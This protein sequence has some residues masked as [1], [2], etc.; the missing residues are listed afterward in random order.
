MREK[1]RKLSPLALCV[2]VTLGCNL[3]NSGGGSRSSGGSGPSSRS[4]DVGALAGTTWKGKLKCD[5]G[6]ELDANYRFADSGNPIY[7]YQTKSGA[8]EVELTSE[9][10]MIRFVPPGGGVTSVVVDA[11]SVSPEHMTNTISV[12]EEKS[13]GQTLDQN[14]ATIQS[15]ATLAGSELDV[16][17]TIR[18]QGTMSQP[19]IV[20]PGDESTVVCRGKLRQ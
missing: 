18:S 8:R 19:G 20:V 6:D 2:A 9:G 16:E 7:E 15:E 12:S 5:D 4:T 3:L 1:L 10:Q 14:R 11:I 17:I 13:S